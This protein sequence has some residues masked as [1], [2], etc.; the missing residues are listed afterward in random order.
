MPHEVGLLDIVVASS[1]TIVE[2]IGVYFLLA[3]LR[4][5][6]VHIHHVLSTAVPRL[7]VSAG[8]SCYGPLRI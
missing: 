1:A 7:H 8:D 4:Q 2:T 3:R 6:V 5:I